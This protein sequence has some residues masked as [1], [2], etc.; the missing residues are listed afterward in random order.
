MFAHRYA[1]GIRRGAIKKKQQQQRERVSVEVTIGE[2]E[3]RRE[4][5]WIDGEKSSR[6]SACNG[7]TAAAGYIV[8]VSG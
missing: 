5:A 6:K 4:S 8:D 7:E 2:I 1:A 3:I